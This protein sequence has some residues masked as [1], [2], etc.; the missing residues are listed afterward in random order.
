MYGYICY[1]HNRININ[2]LTCIL[3]Y[4]LPPTPLMCYWNRI[5]GLKGNGVVF[6]DG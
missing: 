1:F 6:R 2:I 4:S 3:N 5:E